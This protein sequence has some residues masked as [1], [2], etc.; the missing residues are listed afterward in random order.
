MHSGVKTVTPKITR[1][2]LM[3][4]DKRQVSVH[5]VLQGIR[6]PGL[7]SSP[8][9]ILSPDQALDLIHVSVPK[10]SRSYFRSFYSSEYGGIVRE[11]SLMVIPIDDRLF[12][13]G[14]GAFEMCH[15][16]QGYL[17]L[18]D[19]HFER[20][21][22]SVKKVG[23]E[24]PYSEEELKRIILH[25]AAASNKL[26]GFV[27]FWASGGRGTFGLSTRGGKGPAFY[28]LATCEKPYQDFSLAEGFKVLTS[29]VPVHDSYYTTLQSNGNLPGVLTQL[30]AEQKGCDLGVLVDDEG[31]VV[32]TGDCDLGI[33]T[34]TDVIVIP[35]DDEVLP[36]VTLQ[37]ILELLRE[38]EDVS[39]TV[40]TI[41]RR[42]FTVEEAKNAKE[43]F[44]VNSSIPVMGVV[45]WDGQAIKDMS[46]GIN[47][48]GFSELIVEDSEPREDSYY[49]TEI[50]YGYITGELN[51]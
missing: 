17:Y 42:L 49:H 37:R 4:S 18:F 12:M 3:D 15:I 30:L 28:V 29:P 19:E 38:T 31:Y 39:M 43:V 20:F 35:P 45:E 27:R 6:L 8:T 23:I 48:A 36:S 50:P 25:T 11:P 33:I 47:T 5:A 1:R 22:W 9:P 46:S 44:V 16:S 26:N 2:R 24:L 13:Q 10:T 21:M 32:S 34:E 40:K 7:Y 41:Q 14:H 51:E